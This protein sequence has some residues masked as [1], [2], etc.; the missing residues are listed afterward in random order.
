MPRASRT[1]HVHLCFLWHASS[2]SKSR[3]FAVDHQ[4]S[5]SWFLSFLGSLL[6][7]KSSRRPQQSL[8]G[9]R[10]THEPCE[11]SPFTGT[12]IY[13]LELFLRRMN[14]RVWWTY[15]KFEI[16]LWIEGDK[17]V[18]HSQWEFLAWLKRKLWENIIALFKLFKYLPGYSS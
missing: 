15:G 2:V 3:V 1:V 4:E 10:L 11:G 12:E 13:L 14:M 6:A 16:Y 8:S 9:L 18:L 17:L 5:K 7:Q